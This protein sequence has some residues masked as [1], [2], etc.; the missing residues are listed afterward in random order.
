MSA[1]GEEESAVGTTQALSPPCPSR[2]DIPG[3]IPMAAKL[4]MLP[5]GLG[6]EL[7]GE[8]RVMRMS[9]E[10]RWARVQDPHAG[11]A[12]DGSSETKVIA[13]TGI[14][15]RDVSSVYFSP[16][17]CHS[18][19]EERLDMR[20]YQ[21]YVKQAGGM[22]FARGDDRL[23]LKSMTSSL[24]GTKLRAWRTRIR[25]AWFRKLGGDFDHRRGRRYSVGRG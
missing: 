8:D 4:E 22:V 7:K 17:P 11:T 18:T 21:A 20:R 19:F 14:T 24:P 2:L 15:C 6:L 25:G 13:A 5:L 12:V 16:D 23:T 1:G 10:E 9:K 3:P